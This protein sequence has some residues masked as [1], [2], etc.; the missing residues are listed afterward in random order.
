MP[1][2]LSRETIYRIIQRELPEDCYPDGAPTGYFS[3]SDSYATAKVLETAY[4]NLHR[5]YDNYFPNYANERQA[6]WE[7]TVFG[8]QL[9]SALTLLQRQ[10]LVESKLRSQNTIRQSDLLAA[11]YTVIDQSIVVELLPWSGKFNGIRTGAWILGQSPLGYSTFLGGRSAIWGTQK[12]HTPLDCSLNAAAAGIT[13]QDVTDIQN[14]AYTYEVRIFANLTSAQLSA[15]DTA[16]NSAEA[17][18]DRHV[19]INNASI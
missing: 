6:D 8:Y 13:Q 9:D 14:T 12:A 2:Y 7:Y 18:R 10:Q 1:L 15:I 16:L 19:L 4:A 17:A 11:I 3:T 5:I